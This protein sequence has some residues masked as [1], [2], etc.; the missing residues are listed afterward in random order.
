MNQ[1]ELEAILGRPLTSTESSNLDLYINIA[2][3]SLEELICTTVNP[4]EETRVFN[5]RKGYSTAFIDIFH[6]ISEVKIND[7]VIDSDNYSVRQWDKRTGEW[8]N[9][10]VFE[11]KFNRDDVLEVTA[12]WG[13]EETSGS[14]SG[15]PNDLQVLLAGLFD[16]ITK[17]NKQ[18]GSITSKQVEDFRITFNNDIDLDEEFHTKYRKIIAKYS[19]CSIGNIQHGDVRHGSL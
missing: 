16:L 8:F 14:S 15:L 5:T 7:E 12:E 3:Q 2:T 18:D 13:F 1:S 10:L 17:K 6:D 11:N 19:L 9:S 4:I